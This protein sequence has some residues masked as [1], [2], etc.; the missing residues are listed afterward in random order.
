MSD[1]LRPV[2]E[3]ILDDYPFL[4]LFGFL[5]Y[6][7]WGHPLIAERKKKQLISSLKVGDTV[8]DHDGLTGIVVSLN[9]KENYV[10]IRSGT[11]G[12]TY[13]VNKEDIIQ[14]IRKEQ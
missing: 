3:Y 11:K 7:F 14:C 13:K 12:S 1:V 8:T 2:I 5:M 10:T 4:L 6:L 9:G